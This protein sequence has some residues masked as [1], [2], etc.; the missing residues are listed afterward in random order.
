MTC[1]LCLICLLAQLCAV[2]CYQHLSFDTSHASS[3]YTSG[4][5]PFAFVAGEAIAPGTGYWCSSGAHAPGQI[6]TWTGALDTRRSIAGIVLD[7]AYAPGEWKL[8]VSPDGSNFEEAQGWQMASRSEAS[9]GHTVMFE[10]ALAVRA[11]AI[12]MRSPRSWGYFG[13][14]RAALLAEPGPIMIVSGVSAS[15]GEMCLSASGNA[16]VQLKPC[17]A[18]IAAGD[19]SDIFE[20]TSQGELQNVASGAC[21]TSTDGDAYVIL[22]VRLNVVR[23]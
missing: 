1:R 8:L 19:G 21:V 13:L 16:D 7:W 17:L 10:A 15:A 18:T 11:V 3:T 9:Y 2:S 14:S 4:D 5:S 12:V 22:F 6:V 20:F 23:D